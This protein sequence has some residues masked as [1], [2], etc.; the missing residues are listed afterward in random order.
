M[1]KFS[2][3][4]LELREMIWNLAIPGPRLFHAKSIIRIPSGD[5]PKSKYHVKYLSDTEIWKLRCFDFH[6]PPRPPSVLHVCRESRA[7]ALAA[8]YFALPTAADALDADRHTWFSAPDDIL[9]LDQSF[10]SSDYDSL[11]GFVPFPGLARIRNVGLDWRSCLT[12]IRIPAGSGEDDVGWQWAG[13]LLELRRYLRG[14]ETVCFVVPAAR[15]ASTE[16]AL[17]GEPAGSEL[18]GS[19][20]DP[21]PEEEVIFAQNGDHRWGELRGALGRALEREKSEWEWEFGEDF[22]FPEIVGRS[23]IREG[24]VL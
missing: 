5:L 18:L 23:L 14:L 12:K 16:A 9:Y 20:L 17:G 10:L 1:A 6:S 24:S 21:I 15:E 7:A 11:G 4:P 13:R 2:D 3:L 19:R 8:G 22:S